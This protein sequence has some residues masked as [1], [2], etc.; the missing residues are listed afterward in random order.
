MTFLLTYPRV[1][2]IHCEYVLSEAHLV[3]T[4]EPGIGGDDF[5]ETLSLMGIKGKHFSQESFEAGRNTPSL[6]HVTRQ[7]AVLEE[8]LFDLRIRTA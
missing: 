5:S 8:H 4:V 2:G 7:V 1:N 3:F 6:I